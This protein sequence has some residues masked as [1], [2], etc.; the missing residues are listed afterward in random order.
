MG[1]GKGVVLTGRGEPAVIEDHSAARPREREQSWIAH[2]GGG[3]GRTVAPDPGLKL[4]IADE[5]SEDL[6]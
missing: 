2:P 5:D 3:Q 6:G 1:L 4:P